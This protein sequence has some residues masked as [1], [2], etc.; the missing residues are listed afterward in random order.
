MRYLLS[1][2]LVALVFLCG[3]F[4]SSAHEG[5]LN[6]IRTCVQK[7][8]QEVETNRQAS[9]KLE[10]GGVQIKKRRATIPG[11]AAKAGKKSSSSVAFRKQVSSIQAYCLL[12]FILALVFAI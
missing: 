9:R 3:S 12:W 7:E 5:A 8:K 6:T 2:S 1:V 10:I 4:P 11:S